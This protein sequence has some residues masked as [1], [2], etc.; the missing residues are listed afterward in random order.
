MLPTWDALGVDSTSSAST[1]YRLGLELRDMLSSRCRLHEESDGLEDAGGVFRN[2]AS[3]RSRE[4]AELED[5]H[6]GMAKVDRARTSVVE[7]QRRARIGASH[8]R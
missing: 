2:Q 5:D 8:K 7:L 6:V 3:T 4:D 1:R